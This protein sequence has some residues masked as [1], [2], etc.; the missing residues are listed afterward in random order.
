M[1]VLDI[2]IEAL[3][4]REQ[5]QRRGRNM[6]AMFNSLPKTPT[7]LSPRSEKIKTLE[8]EVKKL[9]EENKHL[10][11]VNNDLQNN[12]VFRITKML[13]LRT[14]EERRTLGTAKYRIQSILSIDTL[15]LITFGIAAGPQHALSLISR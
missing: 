15:W 11:K 6:Q 10:K 12:P 8:E 2:S 4:T 9:T 7:V 14:P 13:S 1:S 5:A 3:R